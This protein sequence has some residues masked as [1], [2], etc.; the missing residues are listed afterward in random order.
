MNITKASTNVCFKGFLKHTNELFQHQKL[1]GTFGCHTKV[2]F[3]IY[4]DETGHYTKQ[5]N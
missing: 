5:T 1:G 3:L 4:S 2:I